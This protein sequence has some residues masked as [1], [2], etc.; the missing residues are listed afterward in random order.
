MDQVIDV[1]E[2]ASYLGDPDLPATAST[3]VE[4]AN[5]LVREVV[6]DLAPLPARAKAITLEVAARSIR[7]AGYTSVTTATDS[8]SKTWRR[9]NLAATQPGIY[10]T[11][12]ERAELIAM[13]GVPVSTGAWTIR[14]GAR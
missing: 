1:N 4:L 7:A 5:A 9:D 2:L 14:P 3:Q 10:L 8:T 11:L 12:E 6:G 13:L